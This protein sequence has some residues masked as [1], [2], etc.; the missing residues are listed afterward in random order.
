MEQDAVE[1]LN[2]SYHG[3]ADFII[4]VPSSMTKT[5]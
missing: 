5:Y 3:L 4:A 1:E 2:E